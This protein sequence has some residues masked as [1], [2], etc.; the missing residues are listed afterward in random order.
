MAKKQR[1]PRLYVNK[2]GR[3]YIRT[4]GRKTYLKGMRDMS[5]IKGNKIPRDEAHFSKDKIVQ[6]LICTLKCYRNLIS[7]KPKTKLRNPNISFSKKINDEMEPNKVGYYMPSRSIQ[8]MN[9]EI[10]ARGEPMSVIEPEEPFQLV[11]TPGREEDTKFAIQ[12]ANGLKDILTLD[13]LNK[14]KQGLNLY[15]SDPETMKNAVELG[16]G[17]FNQGPSTIP[18]TSEQVNKGKELGGELDNIKEGLFGDFIKKQLARQ[19]GEIFPY[20]KLPPQFKEFY[21]EPITVGKATVEEENPFEAKPSEEENPFE[22]EPYEEE[23]LLSSR[24]RK[25]RLEESRR[26]EIS[27]EIDDRL[28]RIDDLKEF[29]DILKSVPGLSLKGLLRLAREYKIKLISGIEEDEDIS[30][31]D[32]I[33]YLNSIIRTNI[34]REKKE[35]NSLK[36]EGDKIGYGKKK[37]KYSNFKE[38]LYDDQIEDILEKKTKRIVP[39]IM[40]DEIPTLLPYVNKHTKIFPFV[41]NNKNSD[42]E[43]QHWVA[44]AIN[45]PRGELVYYDSYGENPTPTF[46]RDIKLLIDKINPEVYLK[47][48]INRVRKQ[49]DSQNCGFHASKFVI[50]YLKGEKFPKASGFSDVIKDDSDEGEREIEKFKNY[51]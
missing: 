27:E 43:G 42:S 23:P 9:K 33:R 20:E 22:A 12:L 41:I 45:I 8:R 46:M 32:L 36:E 40:N 3:Y 24:G 10:R 4:G 16:K 21:S 47:F 51:I 14:F 31:I 1:P 34:E 26:G 28:R 44:S 37:N 49:G 5:Y 48:K 17:A 18:A 19:K 38:G 6:Y 15:L 7:K 35:I 13:G 29:L 50:D 25:S 2:K 11:T 39:V 30:P